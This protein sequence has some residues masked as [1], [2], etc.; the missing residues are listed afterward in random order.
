[1]DILS[2]IYDKMKLLA[3]N[4]S[5]SPKCCQFNYIDRDLNP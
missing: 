5:V 2:I 1:M 3:L 4:T